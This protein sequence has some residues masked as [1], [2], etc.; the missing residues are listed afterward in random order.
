MFSKN[1]F[2]STVPELTL[3]EDDFKFIAQVN[4]DL[5]EY[6]KHMENIKH[7]VF[8]CLFVS[9]WIYLFRNYLI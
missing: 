3:T 5:S 6:I 1:N 7:V 2:E 8:D 9:F 4:K